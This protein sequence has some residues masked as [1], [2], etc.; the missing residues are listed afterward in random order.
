MRR[1]TDKFK[2][3]SNRREASFDRV[4]IAVRQ[5]IPQFKTRV[6]YEPLCVFSQIAAILPKWK[7]ADK[8]D[9]DLSSVPSFGS[10]AKVSGAA[11]EL[12]YSSVAIS[13]LEDR[14][15]AAHWQRDFHR[16]R[17]LFNRPHAIEPMCAPIARQIQ[18]F[19]MGEISGGRA[20]QNLPTGRIGRLRRFGRL[21]DESRHWNRK[22]ARSRMRNG[23][24]ASAQKPSSGHF[25]RRTCPRRSSI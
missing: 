17:D 12:Q 20:V 1:K 18:K 4:C 21:A 24:D 16:Q 11:P 10:V 15:N 9:N 14:T 13:L 3:P 25:V 23:I 8:I 2:R 7:L 5:P 6:A 22:L 19:V